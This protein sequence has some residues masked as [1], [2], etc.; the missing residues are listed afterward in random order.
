[1]EKRGLAGVNLVARLFSVD[2]NK[3]ARHGSSSVGH[4]HRPNTNPEEEEEEE[5]AGGLYSDRSMSRPVSGRF[6]ISHGSKRGEWQKGIS[7]G[8]D[9]VVAR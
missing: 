1:M 6:W 4:V 9:P 3:G 7:K 5:E 8:E 2:T